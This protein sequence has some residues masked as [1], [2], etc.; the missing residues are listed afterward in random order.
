MGCSI[1]IGHA[2]KTIL[3]RL[4]S[5]IFDVSSDV[6]N[7]LYHYYPKN[8]TRYLGNGSGRL[9]ANCTLSPEHN[10]SEMMFTCA[11]EDTVFAALTF[12]FIQ[13]PAIILAIFTV[14]GSLAKGCREGF[15]SDQAKKFLS[16]VLLLLVPFPLLIC[17]Q[18]VASIFIRTDQMEYWSI[19]FL[20]GEGSLEAPPQLLLMMYIIFS[21]SEREVA[22][23][24]WVSLVSSVF[25]I[26]KTSINLYLGES[27]W[28][29]GGD[30]FVPEEIFE[31][32]SLKDSMF[33]GKS[34]FQKIKLMVQV[35]P[36]FLTSL[37]FKVGS[38]S[39]ISAFLPKEYLA[40]YVGLGVFVSFVVAYFSFNNS[41]EE[42]RVGF[43]IVFSLFNI[44]ILV[45]STLGSRKEN[46]KPMIAVSTA[47]L[48]LHTITL[49]AL[50]IWFSAFDSSLQPSHWSD[51]HFF[52]KENPALFF[53]AASA[54]IVFGLISILCLW[55]LERQVKALARKEDKMESYWG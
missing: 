36:A 16:V 41:R 12:T 2:L 43:A 18:Q 25:T 29:S 28:G 13:M 14:L 55:G 53:S 39:I 52:F 22:W 33:K 44:T 40:L 19:L 38:I 32:E 15:G 5:N 34:L 54:M 11:E 46:Q 35:S 42:E 27:F 26:S 3:L 37:V 51:H 4:G 7:G 24:T 23:V 6:W 10:A 9:P 8:V 30:T 49:V 50:V 47:W 21:D 45:R 48:V 20:F 1:D 17:V 31:A